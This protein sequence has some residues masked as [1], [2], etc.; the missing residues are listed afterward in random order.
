VAT[1]LN[2]G[3]HYKSL[4]IMEKQYDTLVLEVASKAYIQRL[5]LIWSSPLS[6]YNKMVATKQFAMSAL[7]YLMTTL[8]WPIM[9]LERLDR[10]SRTVI[11]ENT[12]KHPLGSTAMMYLP[13]TLGG[14]GLNSVEREHNQEK[15]KAVV[16][17]Y[18]NEDYTTEVVQ[19][20]EKKERR[21]DYDRWLRITKSIH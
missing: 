8:C 21:Q 13:R 12:G 15:I 14:R 18:I 6:D 3:S 5:L 4:G 9:E 11:L 19:R 17:L 16:R 2:Q 20:F 7:S 1:L 10:E